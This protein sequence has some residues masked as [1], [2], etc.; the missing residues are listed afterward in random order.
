MEFLARA[1]IP[2]NQ[3]IR[4][5]GEQRLAVGRERDAE[6]AAADVFAGIRLPA[7]H[8]LAGRDFPDAHRR[9]AAAGDDELAVEADGEVRSGGRGNRPTAQ[10][11]AAHG[12]VQ[13]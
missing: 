9:V 1:P 4:S 13:P 3:A 2:A 10:L 8:F 11:L 5:V 7:F 12:I 6:A